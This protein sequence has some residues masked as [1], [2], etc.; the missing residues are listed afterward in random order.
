[1][2]GETDLECRS[3][4]VVVGD[5]LNSVGTQAGHGGLGPSAPVCV[6]GDL[7]HLGY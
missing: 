7:N 4:I 5:G 3:C 6:L 2:E 1:M